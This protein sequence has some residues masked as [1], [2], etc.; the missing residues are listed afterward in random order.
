MSNYENLFQQTYKMAII[1]SSTIVN[2]TYV[3]FDSLCKNAWE[4]LAWVRVPKYYKINYFIFGT[5][6][7]RQ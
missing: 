5:S 6:N 1:L 4:T 3:C 2:K 7:F